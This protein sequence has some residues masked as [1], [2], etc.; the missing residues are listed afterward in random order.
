MNERRYS[1]QVEKLRSPERLERL[2]VPTVVQHA[3]DGQAVQS[4]LDVGTG[5]GVFAEAFAARGL[6]VAGID[7]REEMLEAA[8]KYVPQGDFRLANMSSIPFGDNEFDLVFLGLVLHEADDLGKAVDEAYRV[9]SQRVVILEWPYET[10]EFGPPLHHRLRPEQV[11]DTA[12][13]AG[14]K[15]VKQIPLRQLTLFRL[16]KA[17]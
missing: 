16:D 10:G 11:M 8:R 6:R 12:R 17:D 7:L 14:F 4:V 3:L 9:A 15:Q 1:D 13:A 5:S 2:E